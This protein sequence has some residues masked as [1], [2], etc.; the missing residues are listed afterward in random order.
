MKK[1]NIN[2]YMYI[3]ITEE[4]WKHLEKTVG[5]DYINACIKTPNYTKIIDGETWYRADEYTKLRSSFLSDIETIA[6]PDREIASITVR[7]SSDWEF[8]EIAK[9]FEFDNIPTFTGKVNSVYEIDTDIFAVV[10]RAYSGVAVIEMTGAS[11]F[12]TLSYTGGLL[13]PNGALL[14]GDILMTFGY[15]SGFEHLDLTDPEA[16]IRTTIAPAGGMR[17]VM[18]LHKVGTQ[19]ISIGEG[20]RYSLYREFFLY[21]SYII[22]TTN[23]ILTLPDALDVKS[24]VAVRSNAFLLEDEYSDEEAEAAL[25]TYMTNYGLTRHTAI[26]NFYNTCQFKGMG[27]SSDAT[28][29]YIGLQPKER[30]GL[31]GIRFEDTPGSG[32]WIDEN[33][34]PITYP[35]IVVID[36]LDL[37]IMD[38]TNVHLLEIQDPDLPTDLGVMGSSDDY[39]F[40]LK[41]EP[42]S[43]RVRITTLAKSQIP[44]GIT[45]GF[46]GNVLATTTISTNSSSSTY[47]WGSGSSWGSQNWQVSNCFQA[48]GNTLYAT[49]ISNVSGKPAV[50]RIDLATL[51]VE[52]YA[53]LNS[54]EPKS[55]SISGTRMLIGA[56]TGVYVIEDYS[57]KITPYAIT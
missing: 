43:S 20:V 15:I 56:G 10:G 21:M 29:I 22:G 51:T 25:Q 32:I 50:Y 38:D 52:L 3:Q 2:E 23:Y 31:V 24:A 27:L 17:E 34:D 36:E 45:A 16:P 41:N 19:W 53:T 26:N 40:W 48:V 47:G 28:Y 18:Y 57:G 8:P 33:S 9:T 39:I 35:H 1:F 6:S 44:T 11:T 7:A 55:I 4:G 42:S 13:S 37:S 49:I 12:N 46:I 14:S 54:D 30:S 5:I